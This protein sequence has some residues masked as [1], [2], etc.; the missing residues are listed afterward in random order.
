MNNKRI[1][2]E[3]K[4]R[5]TTP[6]NLK[7]EDK[8]LFSTEFKKSFPSIYLK[9]HGSAY[10]LSNGAVFNRRL[11]KELYFCE[12]IPLHGNTKLKSFTKFYF[13]SLS[14]LFRSRNVKPVDK[15]LFLTNIYS[16]NF[17]HW[18]GDVLQKLEAISLK[19]PAELAG[20]K[21]AVPAT[22]NSELARFTLN[23]YNIPYLLMERGDMIKAHQ[24]IQVPLMAPTGNFRPGLMQNMAHRF[25]NVSSETPKQR[26]IFISRKF[27]NYRTVVN[28]DELLP[29]LKKYDFEVV[30]LEN[31]SID[32]QIKL[33]SETRFLAG[34]HGAGLTN[35][36][37]MK[38]G[39]D[40]L[41]IRARGDNK[42]N[43]FYSLAS[44]L[45]H[46]YHYTLAD[47][48]DTSLTTQKTDFY[49][50]PISFED[51]LIRHTSA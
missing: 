36:L 1:W 6:A 17:F 31:L 41:E 39:S 14:S 37:W 25:R 29:V 16:D 43:L 8:H 7:K 51:S 20:A 5:R 26:R 2:R 15:A 48:T 22:C 28:E 45:K 13:D 47:V 44:A 24:L 38:E 21:I 42:N 11:K 30:H 33:L 40:V 18:W 34:A 49:V 9:S 23:K 46:T 19:N 50:D 12:N 27:A 35:M 4:L 32:Q 3:Q 10:I